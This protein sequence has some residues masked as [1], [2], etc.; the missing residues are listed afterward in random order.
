MDF[1]SELG[2]LHFEAGNLDSAKECFDLARAIEAATVDL[3]I[4][5]T[6]RRRSSGSSIGMM[7]PRPQALVRT[8]LC[9]HHGGVN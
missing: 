5:L 6:V 8:A 1:Y 2:R 4:E 9:G 7:R 3:V